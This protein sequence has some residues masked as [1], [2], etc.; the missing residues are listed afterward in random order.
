MD[1]RQFMAGSLAALG[2]ALAEEPVRGAQEG[3]AQGF[4]SLD[5]VAQLPELPADK[6]L[7]SLQSDWLV[8]PFTQRRPSTAPPAKT[9]LP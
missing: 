7:N 2:V 4:A 5:A 9:K 3:N 1:R 6:S 8:T